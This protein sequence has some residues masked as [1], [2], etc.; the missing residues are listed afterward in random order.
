MNG[1]EN[2]R[3]D[4]AAGGRQWQKSLPHSIA[5]IDLA[6]DLQ[7]NPEQGLSS[8]EA[9]R[10][11][12]TVGRN[13]LRSRPPPSVVGTLTNQ[14][15]SPVVYL[16]AA[17]AILAGA[18]GEWSDCIAIS[19]VL[20]INAAIG[21]T[22]EWRALK[23]M[24][25]LRK[26]SA[27]S[28][29]VRRDGQSVVIPADD[30]VPGDVVILEAGDVVTAD[31]RI[32]SSSNL[33]SDES[34]LTG[35]SLPV[36]KSCEPVAP[37][38]LLAERSSMLYKGCI[39]VRG[40]GEGVVTATGMNT[41]LG[42]I[43]HLVEESEPERSPLERRLEHLSR[44]LIWITLGIAGF[45]G[46]AGIYSGQ[47][48]P[49]MIET[50][51]ALAVAAIPEGLPIVATLALA[52][53]MLRMAR[54]NALIERLSAVETLGATTVILT[55]KT[56]TLTEN[57]MHVSSVITPG[58]EIA[59]DWQ[60]GRYLLG[61]RAVTSG[62][63]IGLNDILR[64]AALCN[65]AALAQQGEGGTGDPM[66][67]ALLEAAKANGFKR[68]DLL[69][70][71]PELAEHAFDAGTRMMA[72]V[73]RNARGCF[74]AVKGAPEAVFESVSKVRGGDGKTR[75]FGPRMARQWNQFCDVLAEQGL[76]LLAV[77]GK[78]HVDP[79]EAPYQ[80]LTLYGVVGLQDPPRADVAA[81]LSDARRAGIK[82]IMVTGDHA[83]TAKSIS[84]AIGL[85]GK[86]VQVTGGEEM[87]P[88]AEQ[89]PEEMENMR[90]T[91]VFSRVSPE[92]KLDLITLHQKA[93]EIVA[94]TGDGVNDAPA[95]RKAEIGIAMGQRG[96]Q[97]ARE[98]ADMVLRDDAFSTIIQAVREG[99]VIYT[100]IRRF[101]TYL[102]SCNL[103]EVLVIGL[104]VL[105]GLPLPLL[106]LQILFLNLVTDVFPA[107]A[108]GT[109]EGD[110]DVLAR[111]PR[112]P[113]EPILAASQWR[114]IIVHGCIIA[115]TTL[116]AA[117][118]AVYQFA[119][120]GHE[121]TTMC[122]FTLALAQLWHV[123]NMRNWRDG[124]FFNA[125]TR[126]PFIWLAIAICIALLT[127][128]AFES[129]LAGVL[130]ITSLPGPVWA[131]IL[132][133]SVVPVVLREI[134]AVFMRLQQR[135]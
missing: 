9:D 20:A 10:R 32:V 46:L 102:L 7:V 88:L 56:G 80:G 39:V 12:Q 60:A 59:F 111:P 108:L 135:R 100:N 126:N 90:Q 127:L 43:T 5:A 28:V 133:L 77:A 118:L 52:R 89:S 121:V 74:T 64:A 101:T 19:A 41:E 91:L 95:L 86:G 1:G 81:A 6:A 97:V 85:A 62:S 63:L 51:V 69:D 2:G 58:G 47:N 22:T 109:I 128:A 65:N 40:T 125:L 131:S 57:R 21:F 44:D 112:D 105:A 124:A 48:I 8:P 92:Q 29:R 3:T 107:F 13:V 55:D 132:A 87:K 11:R 99:R 96:T 70:E 38:R 83:R 73:H 134:A 68:A 61:G 84:E 75:P 16:L 76:R 122:F 79:A 120:Q 14:F 26:L 50:A 33:S 4:E 98:A 119:L 110:R 24:E 31:I 49:L 27:H 18:F 72:T 71:M 15:V 123:F 104:A 94:M 67:V 37:D 117:V 36:A 35:E 17:A 30:L 54:H 113:N 23:S 45:V 106:P 129:H 82:V 78:Q 116:A 115:L 42:R 103:S 66:E 114:A 25:A 130:H 53:G 93:G 34:P